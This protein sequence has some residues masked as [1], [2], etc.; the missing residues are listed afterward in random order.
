MIYFSLVYSH[1]QYV[2]GA[3]GSAPKTGP[4]HHP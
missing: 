3:W 4:K 1:L 2:V